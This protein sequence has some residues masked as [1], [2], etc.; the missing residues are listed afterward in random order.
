[1]S[2]AAQVFM[3]CAAAVYKKRGAARS[4]RSRNSSSGPDSS[5]APSSAPGENSSKPASKRSGMS[6]PRGQQKHLGELTQHRVGAD[7]VQ[8]HL[9]SCYLPFAKDEPLAGRRSQDQL[10]AAGPCEKC[11]L[12]RTATRQ[13]PWPLTQKTP[14]S[15]FFVCVFSAIAS[16]AGAS[17]ADIPSGNLAACVRRPLAM[18]SHTR[19]FHGTT[20][21]KQLRTL[22]TRCFRGCSAPACS[23]EC[24]R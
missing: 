10:L 7:R 18:L 23:A 20:P 8:T 14:F 9:T 21:R 3:P 22:K 6:L 11:W 12:G 17:L 4:L 16:R 15:L 24:C 1:M 5:S 19:A 2:H 13:L